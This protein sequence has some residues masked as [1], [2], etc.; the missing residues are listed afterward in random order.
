MDWFTL[1]SEEQQ[2]VLR[3][4]AISTGISEAAIEK[5][6]YVCWCLRQLFSLPAGTPSLVF[7]GGTS[8]S[9]VFAAIQR[10]SEDIDITL[11][12]RHFL[13]DT[14][15]FSAGL[16]KKKT[17]DT[18][19]QLDAAVDRFAIETLIPLL[20][21]RCGELSGGWAIERGK[22]QTVLVRYPT[23][24]AEGSYLSK[25]VAIELGARNVLEPVEA[26]LVRP[27]AAEHFP[28]ITFP[29]APD[30]S[31]LSPV[32]TFWEKAT[33]LHAEYHRPEPRAAERIAR[34]W[35]DTAMLARHSIRERAIADIAMLA[36]VADYKDRI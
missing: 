14:D 12:Q 11:N 28:A 2:I 27:Y 35:Y 5:D 1:T 13:G 23:V 15:L 24:T 22:F 4:V 34:H 17:R 25:S 29:D 33:I 32:R 6:I 10:F 7:K 8:L 26:H 19:E 16:S 30:V 18:L 3:K 31:V 21:E 36:A 20:Q 9:K